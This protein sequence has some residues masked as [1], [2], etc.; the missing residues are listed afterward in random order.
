VRRDFLLIFLFA[1][2]FCA[3]LQVQTPVASKPPFTA[4][5]MPPVKVDRALFDGDVIKLGSL[6]ATA[7]SIPGH[8][9]GSTSF[10]ITV[11]DGNRDYRVFEYCC[12]QDI[13][14]D[15]GRNP[16]F[17]EAAMRHSFETYRK[18]LPVDIY[19]GGTDSSGWMTD[20][21]AKLK[22]GDKMAFVDQAVFRAFTA[23]RE[24]EF[25]EKFR[26]S[27]RFK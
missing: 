24:V 21:L 16:N 9:P 6:T 17:S 7:Y 20:R 2:V 10:V 11:R 23:L 15:V 26:N 14:N 25:E 13:P 1:C 18:V 12:G 22:A 27:N 3:I 8:T 5:D 4:E 19:L